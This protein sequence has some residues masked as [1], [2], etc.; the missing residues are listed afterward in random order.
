MPQ[1]YVTNFAL[2]N[3]QV[4]LTIEVYGFT[5]GETL[6]ISGHATQ[7]GGAFAA[8]NSSQAVPALN[9]DGAAHMY[10][11]ASPSED[12]KKGWAVTVVLR[13]ARVWT[14][15]LAEPQPAQGRPPAQAGLA[16]SEGQDELAEEGT[17]WNNVQVTAGGAGGAVLFLTLRNSQIVL[18]IEVYDF[19]P[20]E[21]LEISGYAAQDGGASAVINDLQSVPAPNPDGRTYIY[22]KASP[23][24]PFKKGRAVT[25]VLRAAR[26]WTTVL[27]ELQPAQGPPP[28]QAGLPP[29]EG[30]R[31]LAEEGTTWN[32]VRAVAYTTADA[33]RAE[34]LGSL[35]AS[36][37]SAVERAVVESIDAA[38]GD[39]VLANWS[40][41]VGAHIEGLDGRVV[42][43]LV[44]DRDYQLVVAFGHALGDDFEY[45]GVEVRGGRDVDPVAFELLLDADRV[46]FPRTGQELLVP[47]NGDSTTKSYRFRA[48]H[49]GGGLQLW[50]QVL[51]LN[52]LL[53]IVTL[54]VDVIASNPDA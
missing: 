13:A 42:D 41:E 5:P 10:V 3:N 26:V 39:P 24:P 4:V 7:D 28:A 21:A 51:Q 6:E 52:R 53:Q 14:T 25:V 27:A 22:V 20:G 48:P 12:F 32:S 19:T 54:T 2:R 17:T 9:P 45:Q 34:S 29:S 31:E 1:Q 8:F 46:R 50:V 38:R 37:R 40:G 43:Q 30:Q 35:E 44:G 33:G 11:T 15:V 49:Q 18:T 47:V 23:S 36:V 16:P